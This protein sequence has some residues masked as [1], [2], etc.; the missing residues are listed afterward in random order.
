[1]VDWRAAAE[2]YEAAIDKYAL[3]RAVV[4]HDIATVNLTVTACADIEGTRQP[5]SFRTVSVCHVIAVLIIDTRRQ[6]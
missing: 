4:V 6:I 3:E 1:M 2:G 5:L